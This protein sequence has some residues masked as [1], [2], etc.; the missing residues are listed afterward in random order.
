MTAM[1]AAEAAWVREHAWTPDMRL[2][3]PD[4]RLPTGHHRLTVNITDTTGDKR[5]P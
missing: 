4:P 1:T 3:D 2:G 5:R